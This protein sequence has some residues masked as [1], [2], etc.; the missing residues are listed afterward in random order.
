MKRLVAILA[1]ALFAL[2]PVT[3]F[4]ATVALNATINSSQV[5]G[6]SDT[7]GIGSAAML[8]DTSTNELTWAIL[9]TGLTGPLTNA[10]FHG[11]AA[12]GINAGVQ[13]GIDFDSGSRSAVVASRTSGRG[14]TYELRRPARTDTHGAVGRRSIGTRRDRYHPI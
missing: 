9:F 3:G 7:N 1:V 5:V 6:G 13:V 12:P 11:P 2:V 10:H 4:A 14:L 8:Y